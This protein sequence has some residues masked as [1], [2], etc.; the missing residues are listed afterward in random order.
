MSKVALVT[1]A[2]R[3]I[4]WA[5]SMRLAGA[6]WTVLVAD[7]DAAAATATAEAITSAGE[8]RARPSS[9]SPTPAAVDA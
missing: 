3:G 2:A 8:K 4:C 6:G 5:I 7:V 1:G 9:T